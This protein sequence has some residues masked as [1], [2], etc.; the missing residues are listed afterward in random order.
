MIPAGYIGSQVYMADTMTY[1]STLPTVFYFSEWAPLSIS[2]SSLLFKPP[3]IP[4]YFSSFQIEL[5]TGPLLIPIVSLRVLLCSNPSSYSYQFLCHRLQY[6]TQEI[7]RILMTYN[8]DLF[9]QPQTRLVFNT[10]LSHASGNCMGFHCVMES[11]ILTVSDRDKWMEAKRGINQGIAVYWVNRT[12]GTI[13]CTFSPGR[14]GCGCPG[15]TQSTDIAYLEGLSLGWSLF[16]SIQLNTIHS[17]G[18]AYL[19]SRQF[20]MIQF[21]LFVSAV[22]HS[23]QDFGFP[24]ACV[25]LYV[26]PSIVH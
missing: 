18:D 23:Y 13:L 25:L 9:I 2:Y 10:I 11:V 22:D 21:I 20:P 19:S 5:R 15:Q 12:S 16:Q 14:Q 26:H 1:Y 3:S 6:D 17:L 24:C 7:C 4:S 8:S